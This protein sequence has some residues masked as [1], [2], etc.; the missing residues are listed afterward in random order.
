M[1]WEERRVLYSTTQNQRETAVK[2]ITHKTGQRKRKWL[3]QWCLFIIIWGRRECEREEDG[4]VEEGERKGVCLLTKKR[5]NFR[6]ISLKKKQTSLW[7]VNPKENYKIKINKETQ[8]HPKWWII[9]RSNFQMFYINILP[10]IRQ[11]HL[12]MTFLIRVQFSLWVAL[13]KYLN[14]SEEINP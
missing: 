1:D 14:S 4:V 3:L 13:N 5:R 7:K 2:Q 11:K 9:L 10:F 12:I 8:K 6:I